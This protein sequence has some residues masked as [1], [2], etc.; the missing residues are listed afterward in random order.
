MAGPDT[1]CLLAPRLSNYPAAFGAAGL[2]ADLVHSIAGDFT[3]E[4]GARAVDAM[5]ALTP[6]PTAVFCANDEMAMGLIGA[7]AR[8][9][10]RV[11]QDISVAGLDDFPLAACLVPS[12]AIIGR[13]CHAMAWPP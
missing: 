2:P 5:L 7:L 12:I 10:V 6:R 9:G 1:M 4:G 11:P 13:P 8:R 3:A